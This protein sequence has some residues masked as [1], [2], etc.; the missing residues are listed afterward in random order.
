MLSVRLT[1]VNRCDVTPG[2]CKQKSC[3]GVQSSSRKVGFGTKGLDCG[4]A[5]PSETNCLDWSSIHDLKLAAIS[6]WPF[7]PY[8]ETVRSNTLFSGGAL[9]RLVQPVVWRGTR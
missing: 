5:A 2:S 6:S 4:R 7:G 8:R 9:Y 3:E 1:T